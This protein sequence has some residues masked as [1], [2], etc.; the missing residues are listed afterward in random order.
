MVFRAVWNH[1]DGSQVA[2]A[3]KL[4]QQTPQQLIREI[5]SLQR[6]RHENI[7][8]LYG[9]CLEEPLLMVR[10]FSLKNLT[11]QRSNRERKLNTQEEYGRKFIFQAFLWIMKA[12]DLSIGSKNTS[13]NP[14]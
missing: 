7:V 13:F 6:L 1:P 14:N 11:K 12:V 8:Q 4:L 3:I 9:V 10:A 2:C 5:V